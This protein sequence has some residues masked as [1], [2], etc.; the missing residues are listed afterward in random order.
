MSSEQS[1][2][3]S[4]IQ[5]L[6]GLEAVRVR[7]SMYIGST[8][9][10]GLHHLVWEVCDNSVDEAMAGHC[11][12]IVVTVHADGSLSVADDGRGIPTDFHEGEGKSG[13]EVALTIL[14][15][16]GKFDKDSYQVSGGLHGVGVS[17]VNALSS[18]LQ[19]DVYQKG[20]HFTQSYVRGVAQSA[21]DIVGDVERTG[22][23]ITFTPD[24]DI[25]SVTDF[26]AEILATRLRE[27]AFLNKG[28][29]IIFVD[30][31]SDAKKEFH[32]EGGIK[33][34]VAYLNK[35]KAPL[36]EDIIYVSCEESGTVVEF[37][38]QYNDSYQ[39]SLFS[40]VNNINTHEGG[41][42]V[43]GFSTALTRS[44]NRYIKQHK[45]T[46][47]SLS[48]SDVREGLVCILSLKVA[49]PQFEGQ[50]KTKLG[51]SEIKGIVDS[52][53]TSALQTFFEENPRTA[54]IIIGKAVTAAKARE[55]ARKAR[56]L[57][58]R[59]GLLD[60]ASL[61][62]KLA[63][64]QEKD[65]AK[66]ELFIVEGMSA[67]GCFS[68]DTKVALVDGRDLTFRELVKEHQEGKNNYCYT[69]DDKGSI[70][71]AKIEH[72]RRTKKSAQVIKIVLDN[73]K[74]IICTPDH[75]FRL[76][77][78]EYVEA[79]Q[80][81]KEMNLAPLRKKLS[82]KGKGAP[83]EG[84][85]MVFDGPKRRW[86]F[87]HVLADEYNLEKEIY[88]PIEDFHRH[89]VDFNKLNNSPENIVRMGAEDHMQLHRDHAHIFLQTPE[90]QEKLRRIRQTPEF[91]NKVRKS[92]LKI[93]DL[94]SRRAK[95][96][97]ENEDYKVYMG[98]KYLE[99]YYSNEEYRNKL[100]KRLYQAQKEYWS[101]EEHRKAQGKRVKE[102]FDKYPEKRE[103]YSQMAKEQWQDEKLLAWRSQKTKEQW[104]P[105]FRKKRE[106]A[107][108][109]TYYCHSIKL[110]K[111]LHE[112]DVLEKYDLV[113]VALND[114]NLLRQ[115]T[116]VNRFFA[117]NE[118]AMVEA[119]AN[120]NHKIKR[121][122]WVDQP[123]DVYDLEITGTHNF[124]LSAG[125]FVHNSAKSGRTRTIQAILPLRGKVLNVEKA[126]LDKMFKNN[127]LLALITALGCGI[128]DEFD[129]S[130][131]R[132][133]KIIL[134][135]DADVDGSH[136]SC[137]L[138]TFFFRYM[139]PLVEAGYVY[140]AMPPLYGVGKGKNKKYVYNDT[141]LETYLATLEK[142][143]VSIQRYK[144]LGEM[145][146][147]QLWETTLDPTRRFLKQISIDDAAVADQTFSM[148]MGDQVPP[149]RE[150]IMTH[151][152][153]V[154]N[155]DV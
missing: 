97:W 61:P 100:L 92:M 73:D 80:L 67:G 122:E 83:I 47:I 64:C 117:G 28:L 141:E 22:T 16:G 120:Y 96:R 20:K 70:K 107:Y 125:V 40:Y 19:V 147:E 50:T 81:T 29:R 4:S 89:H 102:Y 48:G 148:L 113:R 13:V 6:K 60:S 103:E 94:L 66:C 124:A 139:K 149:R 131:L 1:Y 21:L 72:P 11:T 45:L 140:L 77:S 3:A 24:A 154:K 36:H 52:L 144:G 30:E 17:C 37:A 41:T 15:A 130:K 90:V 150:F 82:E 53:T 132:Y 2:S 51:N 18:S 129:I 42:H 56:D 10:K 145:N 31:R 138:L 38:M 58:R 121:I 142:E 46:D 8:D 114:K 134:M 63:D 26:D 78:N 133:H 127:E 49:E 110:M 118:R 33:S 79:K 68:G 34:Y 108:N 93:R 62:G 44:V 86:F 55:A 136:I 71:I 112:N 9:A 106:R 109:K 91:K 85:E 25:F 152:L 23:T 75:K 59:K 98:E 88:S 151:A 87:T 32:Y 128:G 54:K 115:D 155:L 84:Y 123:M 14:H 105:E 5:V 12:E 135:S 74:E 27:L 104:T 99:F 43:S 143:N 119:I 76:T 153:D 146:P 116:F 95:K 39:E 57:T 111:E 7:P 101:N 35:T 69:L 65:P 126:R 137:L